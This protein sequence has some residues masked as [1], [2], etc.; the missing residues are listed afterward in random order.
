MRGHFKLTLDLGGDL[1]RT[2]FGIQCALWRIAEAVG[3]GE[4]AVSGQLCDDK[5][6]V[7]GQWT[8]DAE[9]IDDGARS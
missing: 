3:D 2:H 8:I 1:L 7:V 5:G 4:D 9:P 6:N